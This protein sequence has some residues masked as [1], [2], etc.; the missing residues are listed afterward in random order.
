LKT[1][2]TLSFEEGRLTN[3]SYI[4]YNVHCFHHNFAALR[5]LSLDF[6]LFP[7]F[8]PSNGKCCL[9]IRGSDLLSRHTGGVQEMFP[10]LERLVLDPFWPLEEGQARSIRLAFG[11]PH[12]EVVCNGKL[13]AHT[14]D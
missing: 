6:G 9:G 11:E 10:A 5:R 4:W 14:D 1:F 3:K 8:S 2:T 12:L 13:L 7:N